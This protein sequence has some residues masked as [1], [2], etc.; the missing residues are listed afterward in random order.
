MALGE[1]A[2][3]IY[4]DISSLREIYCS[5]SKESLQSRNNVMIILYHYETGTSIRIALRE[6]D[7]DVDRFE[8]DRSLII[9]DADGILFR[10]NLDSVMHYLKS[11]ELLA[12]NCG[13]SGIDIIIEMGSFKHFGKEQELLQCEMEFNNISTG[14]RSSILCCYHEKDIKAFDPN[15]I[16]EIHKFHLT[17]YIVKEEQ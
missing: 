6:F 10:P 14:S 3:L 12:I 8:E 1:H 16:E 11:L 13:K 4:N 2:M 5:L 17:S 15:I 7:I 9:R